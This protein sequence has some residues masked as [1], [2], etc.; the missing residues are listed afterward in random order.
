MASPSPVKV[1]NKYRGLFS[2][3]Q[4]AFPDPNDSP[5]ELLSPPDVVVAGASAFGMGIPN[6]SAGGARREAFRPMVTDSHSEEA[7]RDLMWGHIDFRQGLFDPF[8]E[9]GS[10]RAIAGRSGFPIA[11]VTAEIQAYNEEMLLDLLR[12]RSQATVADRIKEFF[13]L[14]AQDPDEPPIVMESLRSLVGFVLQTRDLATPIIGSDPEGLMELEWHL[15]DNGNPDS[16][17]GR[18]N[19]VVSLKFL[20]SGLIQYVA[21]SG[22]HREG[23]E[24]L[25]AQGVSTKAAMMTSLGE[26]ALRITNPARGIDGSIRRWIRENMLAYSNVLA[27][28]FPSP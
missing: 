13:N 7:T 27:Q 19:G 17:W 20:K 18:G 10:V 22:P 26:F 14:R 9:F 4:W 15:R 11:T 21:L 16:Y 6:P 25:E 3:A 8:G 2:S 5:I 23:S 12:S 28:G 24:R 1:S